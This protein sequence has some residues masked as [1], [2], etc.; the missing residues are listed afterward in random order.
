MTTVNFRVGG[1][2]FDFEVAMVSFL[3]K[4]SSDQDIKSVQ[5]IRSDKD[6][7]SVQD[8][9]SDQDTKSDHRCQIFTDQ[10]SNRRLVAPLTMQSPT[11]MYKNLDLAKLHFHPIT[12]KG[13]AKMIDISMD[14]N[15]TAWAHRV[16]LQLASDAEP[17][18]ARWNLALPMEGG[19]ESKR[20][21]EFDLNESIREFFIELDELIINHVHENAREIF[22]KDLKREQV[23]EKYKRIIKTKDDEEYF[24]IKV[25]SPSEESKVYTKIGVTDWKSYKFGGIDDLT[26]NAKVVPI[27][28]ILGLWFAMDKF[29]VSLQAD[30]LLVEPVKQVSFIDNFV[31][32]KPIAE[33]AIVGDAGQDIPE[34][35]DAD[36]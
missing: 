24:M 28:K 14:P 35:D 7:K 19:E 17:L 29:G 33:D 16:V 15:S 4:Y 18:V 8:T 23:E 2:P 22:K 20:S 12:T 30:K 34:G 10:V 6:S 9:R 25:R 11:I 13:K 26:R 36:A 27:V 21:W 5:D 3:I 31:L 32:S 1:A